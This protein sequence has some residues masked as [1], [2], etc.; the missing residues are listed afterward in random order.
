MG[1]VAENLAVLTCALPMLILGTTAAWYCRRLMRELDLSI[2]HG[3]IDA[4]LFVVAIVSMGAAGSGG[5]LSV[6]AG[7]ILLYLSFGLW[8]LLL[9]LAMV[10][11]AIVL[12]ERQI[13]ANRRTR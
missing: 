12:A 7:A 3:A 10:V 9:P 8:W 2:R 6:V 1:T 5:L 13:R 11:V 4:L